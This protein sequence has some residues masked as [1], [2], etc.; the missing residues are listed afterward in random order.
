MKRKTVLSRIIGTLALPV[1]MYLIMMVLCYSN[2]KM[3]FGTWNMWRTLI[4]DIALS[5]TCAMGIG[6]QFKCGRFDFSGGAIML[7]TS[8]VAGNIALKMDNSI[9]AMVVICIAGCVI[10]SVLVA[11]FYVFG[12]VPIVITTI[13]FAML[14]ESV[15]CLIYGSRGINIV[16]NMTL[17]IFSTY[18]YALIPLALAIAI[19]A[20]YSYC[21]VSG[22]QSQLLA[23]NQQAAVNIGIKEKKNVII[24]YVFSGLIFGCATIIYMANGMHRAATTSMATVG[25]LF[26]N[27]LPVFIG[28]I[29]GVF[30]GDTIGTIVGSLTLCLMSYGLKAVFSDELG[31]AISTICMGVFILVI[32]VIGS[33]GGNLVKLLR[34]KPKEE[35]GV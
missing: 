22:K 23:N 3:Y 5:I 4:V 19:Y 33:Q 8:I 12:R 1:A 15:T 6:L 17:R 31:A 32:N 35:Q 16:S 14:Y 28:L 11:I 10:L 2:G 30:C 20:F 26:S 24:S 18:P 34:R 13:G 29:V 27:I 7:L 25:E 9:A 21:T